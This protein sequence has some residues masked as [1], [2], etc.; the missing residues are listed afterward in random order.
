MQ[1]ENA[2]ASDFAFLIVLHSLWMLLNHS[3]FLLN[4]L[5]ENSRPIV[6]FKCK[7]QLKAQISDVA[8]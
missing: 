8:L 4:L 5:K 6:K 7:M 1:F 3:G 2:V